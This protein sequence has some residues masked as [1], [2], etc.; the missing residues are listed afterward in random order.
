[1][2]QASLT[3]SA[4]PTSTKSE[5]TPFLVSGLSEC[6]PGW[7]AELTFLLCHMSVY[8]QGWIE[9][10]LLCQPVSLLGMLRN[11]KTEKF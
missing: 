8:I 5:W 9:L 4:V 3:L 6:T 1:M 2:L 10:K 11:S 7:R